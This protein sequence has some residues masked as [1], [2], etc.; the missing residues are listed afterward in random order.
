MFVVRWF[1]VV[2]CMV[3][4]F[5]AV[6]DDVGVVVVVIGKWQCARDIIWR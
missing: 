4:G 1:V 2:V 3:V 6:G 5:E